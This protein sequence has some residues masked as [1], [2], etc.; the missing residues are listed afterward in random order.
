MHRLKLQTGSNIVEFAFVMPLLVILVFGIMD[1]SI[2]LYN[3]AVITNAVREGA[4]SGIVFS[5]NVLRRRLNESEIQNVVATYCSNK[6][7]NFGSST[8]EPRAVFNRGY[9]PS[10][11]DTLTVDFRTPYVYHYV[12]ISRLFPS[13]DSL[14]LSATSVMRVE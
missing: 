12:M 13:L 4:R 10:S 11:G 7:I 1:F 2:G 3:K 5:D 6:L 9:P 14:S 8:V